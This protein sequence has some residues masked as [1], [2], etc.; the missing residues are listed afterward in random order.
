M[1]AIRYFKNLNRRDAEAQRA[2]WFIRHC[3]RSAA[4]PYRW[5]SRL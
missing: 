2:E 3:E 5:F 4:I 1:P